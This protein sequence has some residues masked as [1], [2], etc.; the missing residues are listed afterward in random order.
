MDVAQRVLGAGLTG[1]ILILAGSRATPGV[2]GATDGSRW[3]WPHENRPLRRPARPG[4]YP[5]SETLT[6]TS[7]PSLTQH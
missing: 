5:A 4:A 3:T 2:T 7:S 1:D 6:A